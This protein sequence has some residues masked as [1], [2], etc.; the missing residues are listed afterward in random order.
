MSAVLIPLLRKTDFVFT[1][2]GATGLEQL[3]AKQLDASMFTSGVAILRVHQ[4]STA[5]SAQTLS[6]LIKNTAPT[7][8]DPAVDYIGS[9]IATASIA[10]NT[11]GTGPQT[12]VIIAL[13][14]PIA[15]WLRAVLQATQ[16][17]QNTTFTVTASADLLLRNEGG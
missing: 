9:T 15:P 11:G 5:G 1:A 12:P 16:A 6:L 10:I 17:T 7:I 13:T 4:K 8:D 2:V 3:L 14:S